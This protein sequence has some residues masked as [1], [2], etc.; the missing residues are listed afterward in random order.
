MRIQVAIPEAHVDAPVLDA[1]L[2]A[3][4]RLNEAL[5]KSGEVPLFEDALHTHGIRWRPEPPGDEHFDHAKTVI[6]RRWGDCDD[7]GP[8]QAASLRVSGKDPGAR[9]RVRRSGPRRWHAYV[10][11]SDGSID[12]PSK[13]AGM[14][15][16]SVVG[17]EYDGIAG[18]AVPLMYEPPSAAVGGAYIVKPAIALRPF[19]GDW[20]ARADLPWMWKEHLQD[21]KPTPSD[22][23]M[24]S[25][26]ESPVAHT[27]L[28]GAIDGVIQLGHCAGIAHPEHL[29]RLS[30]ISDFVEG[31]PYDELVQVYGEEIAGETA[32]LMGS[33]F[34]K[35]GK[36]A[37]GVAKGAVKIAK[38][39]AEAAAPL[40]AIAKPLV[41]YIPGIGPIASD[42]WD[43]AEKASKVMNIPHAEMVKLLQHADVWPSVTA[44]VMHG[45]HEMDG[46]RQ[47]ATLGEALAWLEA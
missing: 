2:E 24:V 25:L 39:A 28:T 40:A 41:K 15:R 21:D 12:D 23:A 20:Q 22:Y 31:R 17:M 38:T 33:F 5:I 34:G 7:L 37:K 27:A 18:A 10:E 6:A 8:Y 36:V 14:G 45:E 43:L 19:K 13:A 44:G 46:C 11:R 16:S 42:V 4:T 1:A 32:E 3:T 26:H 29:D 30:C 9:A 35:L 47:V